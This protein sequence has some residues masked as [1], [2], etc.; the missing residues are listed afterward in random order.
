MIGKHHSVIFIDDTTTVGSADAC[1]RVVRSHNR[2]EAVI[3]VS[4][5]HKHEFVYTSH[6]TH[7]THASEDSNQIHTDRDNVHTLFGSPCGVST[8]LAVPEIISTSSRCS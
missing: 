6:T 7:T 2:D 1:T 3:R 8:N 5:A 4:R